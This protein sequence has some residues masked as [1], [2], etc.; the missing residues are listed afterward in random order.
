[1]S[2]ELSSKSFLKPSESQQSFKGVEIPSIET[3]KGG[4]ALKSIDEKFSVNAVNGSSSISIPIP[5]TSARALTPPD[6]V[7]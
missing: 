5:V 3:P 7:F 4:G 6:E 2:Y 1:M